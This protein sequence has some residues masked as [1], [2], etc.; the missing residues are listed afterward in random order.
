MPI[1]EKKNDFL[2]LIWVYPFIIPGSR[3]DRYNT[4]NPRG[5]A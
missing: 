4:Y 2:F 1:H 5:P 3:Q